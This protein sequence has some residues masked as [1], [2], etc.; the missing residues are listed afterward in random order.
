M[1]LVI[2]G[3]DANNQGVDTPLVSANARNYPPEIIVSPLK[4]GA[5][6]NDPA[7]VT[8]LLLLFTC[9]NLPMLSSYYAPARTYMRK[10][11]IA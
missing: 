8:H 1:A 5:I 6:V 2:A 3:A 9:L 10:R 7:G 4:E 11:W